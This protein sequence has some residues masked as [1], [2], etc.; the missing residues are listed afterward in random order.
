MAQD[1]V[2]VGASAGG[3]EALR[4][5]V[6]GMPAELDAAVLVV[7][8]IPAGAPSALAQILA[9]AGR[10]PAVTAQDGERINHGCI[11]VAPSDRHMLVRDG[12]IAL[13][14]GPAEHGHRPAIDALFRS[15]AAHYGPRAIGV[16]LSGSGDD[17]TAGLTAIVEHG[18][19]PIVQD[20][21][22]ALYRS[23]PCVAMEHLAI[24]HVLHP[25][26]IGRLVGELVALH[27]T[28]TPLPTDELLPAETTM[29]EL[30]TV[31]TGRLLVR[32]TGLSCPACHSAMFELGDAL[33]PRYRCRVGHV[34][35]SDSLL[36]AQSESVD[37]ALWT[38]LRALMECAAL[39]RKLAALSEAQDNQ[40]GRD[41]HNAQ[42][43]DTDRTTAQIRQL[44]AEVRYLNDR[45]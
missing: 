32:P 25:A 41:R 33:T 43:A 37:A 14:R 7:L 4:T 12:R 21:D 23:M 16:I 3:V 22:T 45:S 15:A 35:S 28:G 11:Y 6:H 9:R 42:A 13:S 27:T 17:G 31:T 40:E 1:L 24:D 34:W 29:A 8:H 18:G 44:L 10:L 20:P 5:M 39:S 2:V 38:A 36:T 26:K 19:T 30:G